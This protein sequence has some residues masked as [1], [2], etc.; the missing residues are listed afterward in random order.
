M[1][2]VGLRKG[3]AARPRRALRFVVELLARIDRAGVPGEKLFRADQAPAHFPSGPYSADSAW[4][5]I[6]CMTHNLRR[7]TSL[8]GLPGQAIRAARTVRRRLLTL[9]GRLTR[10]ARQRSTGRRVRRLRSARSGHFL[11]RDARDTTVLIER[12]RTAC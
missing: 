10:N 3:S 9:P 5:M 8:P 4:T 6:A 11:G 7:W 12:G 1:L 2:H